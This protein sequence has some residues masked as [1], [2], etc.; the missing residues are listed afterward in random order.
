MTAAQLRSETQGTAEYDALLSRLSRRGE[1]DLDRVEPAVREILSAVRNEGDAGLK[2]YV[3]RFEKRVPPAWLERDYGG[4]AAL[5]S[6]PQPV[7]EALIEATARIRRYHQRQAEALGG[8][9]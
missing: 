3:E 6:L 8:F 4:E 2:R 1:S 7:A 9:E 5:R